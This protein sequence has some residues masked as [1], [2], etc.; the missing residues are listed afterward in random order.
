M[1]SCS[2]GEAWDKGEL[3]RSIGLY[4]YFKKGDQDGIEV[5]ANAPADAMAYVGHQYWLTPEDEMKYG[6]MMGMDLSCFTEL[7]EAG[8]MVLASSEKILADLDN[9]VVHEMLHGFMDDYN[10][11]GMGGAVNPL[12]YFGDRSGNTPEE[13]TR[14]YYATSF[15]SWFKEGLA[16]AVE[17]VYQFRYENFQ[18]LSYAGPQDFDH[19]YTAEN[20]LNAY[21]TNTFVT[22]ED[23]VAT[24]YYDLQDSYRGNG[25]STPSRYVTG[26]LATLY[27]GDLAAQK[28]GR[29]KSVEL[30][31][32]GSIDN[33][34][35]ENIRTG[36]NSILEQLHDGKT[37][38]AVIKDISGG[39]YS[40]TDDFEKR[41]IKG[42]FT[43]LPD[44]PEFGTYHGDED[45][46]SFCTSF[47]NYMRSL[48]NSGE[49]QY[50]PNG[51]ILFDF[52]DDYLTPLDRDRAVTADYYKIIRSTEHVESSVPLEEA[53]KNGGK[54]LSGASTADA[55]ALPAAK[56][57][58]TQLPAAAKQTDL[59][60]KEPVRAEEA[61]PA[62]E[63]APAEE[64]AP[65]E[66]PAPAE[67]AVPAEKA[68]P[69]EEAVAADAA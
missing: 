30:D 8:E 28:L 61:A 42:T 37:L 10:R 25:E 41:F 60:A 6:L 1:C 36:V 19:T 12:I 40:D 2:L 64:A 52:D 5:H 68:V 46:L 18:L 29:P 38:D 47:L 22:D 50:L 31:E 58:A 15:P 65:V 66:E 63:P 9:T 20:L 67:E 24:Y 57:D 14:L 49:Q 51:S 33:I 56:E 54:S 45:S 59:A 21:L 27:L 39:N 4:L 34:S 11:V 43:P 48:K 62:E 69:A 35:S 23:T 55:T 17:N 7:N 16:S 13:N 3:S 53:L 44:N 26:Y 32:D